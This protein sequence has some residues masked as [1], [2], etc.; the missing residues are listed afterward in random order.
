M[1]Y[2]H[3]PFTLDLPTAAHSLDQHFNL[4]LGHPKQHHTHHHPEH[5]RGIYLKQHPP[6]AESN[7][8]ITSPLYLLTSDL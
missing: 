1:L 2:F 6:K 3:F 5:R 8:S 4:V 7:L